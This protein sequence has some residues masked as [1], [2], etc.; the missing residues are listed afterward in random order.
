MEVKDILVDTGWNWG[1]IPFELPVVF[2]RMIQATPTAV[3]S[4]GVDKLA[5]V[6]SPKG[7]FN[8]SSAYR[9]AIGKENNY[10]SPVRWIWKADMLPRIKT[11]LWLCT[12][13]S[14]AVKV[15]LEKRSVVHETL[16]PICQGGSETILHALWDCTHIKHVWNQLDVTATNQAFWRSNL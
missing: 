3:V 9:I 11:F 6:D 1:K 14:I 4:R 8:L 7:T 10:L 12:H 5:W 16:C 15:C 13:N 2:K